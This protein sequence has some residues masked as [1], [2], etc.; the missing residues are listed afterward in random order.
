M[1]ARNLPVSHRMLLL[2]C[3]LPVLVL[4]GC[5]RRPDVGSSSD[6]AVTAP[7][8]NPANPPG[9]PDTM[10]QATS[11]LSDAAITTRVNGALAKDPDLSALSIDVDTEHGRVALKGTAPDESSK[12]RAT[13]LAQAVE[14]VASVDN[15]LTVRR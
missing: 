10:S 6:A 1:N 8:Q 9:A 7:T 3:A 12:T 4:T 13:Q 15:R 14:G 11:K 5:D 2:Q